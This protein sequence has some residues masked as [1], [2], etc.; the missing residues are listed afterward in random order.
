MP[1]ESA[2]SPRSGNIPEE[3]LPV[4]AYRSE[5]RVVVGDGDVKDFVAVRRVG[6]DEAGFELGG[7][8]FGG[9]VE[10]DGAIGGAGEDLNWEGRGS[11]EAKGESRVVGGG[12]RY[13]LA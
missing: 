10:V 7:V 3:D 11:V 9:V 5:A 2:Q 1:A 12:E 6:L 8:G 4:P 13:V